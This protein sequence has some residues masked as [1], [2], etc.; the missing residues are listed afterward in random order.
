MKGRTLLALALLAGLSGCATLLRPLV[1]ARQVGVS[2]TPEGATVMLDGWIVGQTPCTIEVPQSSDGVITL[3]LEGYQTRQVALQKKTYWAV[4]LDV[5]PVFFYWL[6]VL[7]V[8]DND[9]DKSWR[10]DWLKAAGFTLAPAAGAVLIDV[11]TESYRIFP[12][13]IPAIQVTLVKRD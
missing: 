13:P 4:F 3:Q 10:D 1:P 2:S 5:I 12:K 9:T 7:V 6:A 11:A 8:H